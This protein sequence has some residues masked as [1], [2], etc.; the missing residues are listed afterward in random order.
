[1]NSHTTLAKFIHWAFTLLYA[2]GIFKQ[3]DDLSELEEAS[4][5]NFEIL[6]A[7]IF[8]IIVLIRY[9]YMKDTPALLGAHEDVPKGHLF[10]AKTVH[11]LVYFSLIMLPTT[12]LLIAGLF[13]LGMRGVDVAIALH[14]FSAFLSYIVI[15]LHVGASLYSRFKGEGMWNAMVPIWKETGKNDSNLIIKL[16]E[17]EKKLYEKVEDKFI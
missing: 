11:R 5:L 10:I 14:E 17:I 3:V 7:T 13:N 4:L 1:M 2:Y 12:G 16:E 15:A 9:F 6:F 8:L